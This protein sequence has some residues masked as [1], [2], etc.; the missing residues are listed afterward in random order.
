MKIKLMKKLNKA[1]NF[2][3]EKLSHNCLIKVMN[4]MKCED[5]TSF[6]AHYKLK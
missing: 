2:N 6:L 4:A 3:V 1:V 5:M